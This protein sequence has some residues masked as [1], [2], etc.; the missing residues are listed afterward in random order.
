MK[1]SPTERKEKKMKKAVVVCLTG[2]MILGLSACGSTASVSSTVENSQGSEVS[3]TKKSSGEDVQ[4]ESSEVESSAE[5]SEA[6]LE[7]DIGEVP[8]FSQKPTI[9]ETVLYDENNVRITATSLQYNNSSVSVALTFENDSDKDLSFISNSLGYSCNYVNDFMVSEGYVYCDVPSGETAEDE[10]SF[11]YDGLLTYG[12]TEMAEVG[13][14]FMISDDDFNYIYTG[15]CPLKTS[16][17]DTYD[18]GSENF[19]EAISSKAVMN[20]YGYTVPYYTDEALY[21]SDAMEVTSAAFLEKDGD[22]TLAL[23]VKNLTDAAIYVQSSDIS[24]NG[25]ILYDSTW[26]SNT[27]NAGKKAIITLQ[28]SSMTDSDTELEDITDASL[29]LAA[30]AENGNEL[31]STT[32]EIAY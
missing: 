30:Y 11:S 29:K 9:E 2:M 28:F 20:A 7:E 21:N 31:A 26:S 17:A 6:D 32:L 22:T 18:S 15:S 27:I 4:E 14:G 16:A 5:S 1:I 23:E 8:E 25:N 19:I 10:A 3:S 24:G 13:I 12:I